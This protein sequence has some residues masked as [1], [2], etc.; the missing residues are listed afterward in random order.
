M[1]TDSLRNGDMVREILVPC[2]ISVR[3]FVCEGARWLVMYM[4]YSAE[5]GSGISVPGAG[6]V[7]V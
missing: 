6:L 7:F 2:C 3:V 1:G 5:A 4:M